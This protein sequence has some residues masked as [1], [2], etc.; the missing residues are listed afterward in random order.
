MMDFA[1]RVDGR[2]VNRKVLECLVKSGAFDGIAAAKR[3]SRTKMFLAIGT[4]MEAAATA[5][6]ERESGQTSLLALFGGAGPGAA[7]PPT[8]DVYADGEEW[9]PKEKLAF[10]K[11][12]LGFY[13]SGHPLDRFTAEVKRFANAVTSNCTERGPR[14]EVMLGG[15]VEGFQERMAKSGSGKY[16]F[17]TLEDQYGQ[18]EFMVGSAKLNDYRELLTRG[19]PLLVTGTVD[20]PFGDGEMVRERLRFVD[21]KALAGI[22]AERSSLIDIRLNAEHL[23]EDALGA[24]DRLLRQHPGTCRARLRL[25]IP[26]RSETILDLPEDYKVAASEELLSKLEQLFGDRVAVLR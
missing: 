19:E 3:V 4:A 5:Q 23:T 14:A 22:R 17:F 25:E 26:Q 18:I 15:V 10:E 1:G 13:I 6:R 24:L 9:S 12:G 11:E 8:E 7:P 21:A 16:A 20:A 2:K